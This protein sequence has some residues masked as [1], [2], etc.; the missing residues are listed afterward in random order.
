MTRRGLLLLL[1]GLASATLPAAAAGPADRALRRIVIRHDR[2]DS[3]YVALGARFPAVA[4]VGRAGDGTLIAPR[5][6]LTAGHVAATVNVARAEVM[7]N[8]RGYRIARAFAH[9]A[10]VELG[11][12]D[13]GLV[14]LVEP[15]T[16]VAPLALY[17]GD[18]EKGREVVLVGHGATRDGHGGVWREDGVRRG[19]TNVVDDAE[20]GILVFRFDAP[21]GGTELEGA[22]GR[23]DSGGP[24]LLEQE[25][26]WFVIGVSSAGFDGDAG[27]G[28][29]GAVDHFTR[30][31]SYLDWIRT[32]ATD[33]QARVD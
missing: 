5:W 9:P 26:A 15:V 1:A 10:W 22:P 17:G 7:I 11:P 24:A 12:H 6:V 29:Y 2:P 3:L 30:V 8:G 19:A 32:Y 33:A 16:D 21:P 4:R 14:E 18:D 23:G 28:T 27:P 31:S 13:L 20:E 25:S